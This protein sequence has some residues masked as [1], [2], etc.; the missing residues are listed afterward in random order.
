MENFIFEAKVLWSQIDANQHL[1]HSAYADFCAQARMEML[2][3][4]GFSI[5]KLQK[6]RI[7]PVLFREELIYLRE[8]KAGE[9]IVVKTVLTRLNKEA[10]KWSFQQELFNGKGDKSA[11]INVDG[12]WIDLDKRK[13]TGLPHALKLLFDELPKSSGFMED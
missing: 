3:K 9:Q 1:R 4:H 5:G 7:G 12:A 2:E 10:S 13:L 6:Y 11:V 8:I